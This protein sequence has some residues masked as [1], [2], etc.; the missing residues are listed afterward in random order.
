MKQLALILTVLTLTVPAVG[1]QKLPEI[2]PYHAENIRELYIDTVNHHTA[3]R[4]ILH[5]DT[6]ALYIQQDTTKQSWFH[7][8]IFN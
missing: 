6:N 8:K 1:Q 5:E 7:R 3:L 2:A 4:K